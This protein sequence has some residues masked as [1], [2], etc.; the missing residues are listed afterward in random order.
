MREM[1]AQSE[2]TVET[3]ERIHKQRVK[4]LEDQVYHF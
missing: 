4:N 1:Q 3:R 2:K